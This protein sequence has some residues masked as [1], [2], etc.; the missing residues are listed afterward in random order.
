MP[1]PLKLYRVEGAS[2]FV[3]S[4][5]REALGLPQHIKAVST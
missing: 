1:R 5:V 4:P 3:A 2:A